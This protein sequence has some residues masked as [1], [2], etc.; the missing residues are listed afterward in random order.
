MIVAIVTARANSK[1]IPGKNMIKVGGKPLVAH[2]FEIAQQTKAFD[3]VI[4]SSDM[5]EAI[6]L[7]TFYSRV[8]TPFVRPAALS[9]DGSSQVDVVNHLLDFLQGENY[10]VSHFVLLQPTAP[11]RQVA[12][13]EKGVALLRAGAQSVLGVTN[14][15]HHPADYLYQD[16]SGKNHFL[17]QDLAGKQRQE[18]TQ[19][20]FNNGAFYGCAVDYFRREQR[21]YDENTMLLHMGDESLIDIDT[22]FDLELANIFLSRKH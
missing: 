11:F 21:F 8:E 14:V 19:M 17:M 7:A 13:M 3:R 10:P 9:A 6:E 18:F 20:Y 1:G 4:F 12:E 16:A 15:M 22:P 5:K 2:T